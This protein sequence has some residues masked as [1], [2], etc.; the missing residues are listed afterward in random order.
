[1]LFQV[2]AAVSAQS[3]ILALA[4]PPTQPPS[5]QQ[6]P[7]PAVF[8]GLAQTLEAP[9]TNGGWSVLVAKRGGIV[10]AT[11][12]VVVTSDGRSQ[13]SNGPCAQS[14]T[15]SAKETIAS[16]VAAPWPAAEMSLSDICSDCRQTLVVAAR[17]NARGE[18]EIR[19]A[20][21]DDVTYGRA[22][23]S[24]RQLATI[25]SAFWTEAR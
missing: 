4:L 20:F 22:P 9:N 11:A 17:R 16:L 3:L 12:N 2:V 24:A 19:V 18:Q 23:L 7:I 5:G 10:N 14:L 15:T 8:S 21:W 13:C 6:N 1:M 25:A